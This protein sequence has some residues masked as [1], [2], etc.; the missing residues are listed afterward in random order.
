MRVNDQS[1][2]VAF[3]QSCMRIFASQVIGRKSRIPE[4]GRLQI[5]WSANVWFDMGTMSNLHTF[6][7]L[8]D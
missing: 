5:E 4:F 6:K 7:F 3:F 8:S 2:V 1:C